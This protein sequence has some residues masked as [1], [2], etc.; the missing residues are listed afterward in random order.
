MVAYASDNGITNT[1]ANAWT[2]DTG[3]LSIWILGMFNPSPATT[4]VIPFKSGPESELGP[5]VN[6]AYFGKVPADRLVVKD[7][8]LFFSGDG[9]VPEQDRDIAGP[10]QALRRQLRR[11]RPGP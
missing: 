6:D 3:L 9:K 1:G 11:R 2:K 10:G 4:I 8:V 5:A 7:G